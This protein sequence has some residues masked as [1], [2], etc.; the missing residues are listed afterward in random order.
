LAEN[1]GLKNLHQIQ[2]IEVRESILCKLQLIS[3]TKY[4]V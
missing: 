2:Y 1:E 4:H 3:D